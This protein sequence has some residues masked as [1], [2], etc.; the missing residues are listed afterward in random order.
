MAYQID[1][2][3]N[4]TLT[5]VEDG[6]VDQT[7]DLKF[8]GKNYAGYGE[9]QNEN[10]LFLLENFSGATAPARPLSGQIW[11]DTSVA[12]LKF[13][14]G[15]KWRTNGGSEAAATQPSG[16]SIGDFW[17]DTTN[18]QL[19]VYNG[20]I[21][22]LV[23]PQN[24]GDGV[25]Q[26]QSLEL[27]D[28][29]GT[30]RNVIAGTLNS[31]TVM[32]LSVFE[33]DI[34]ASNAITGFDRLKK[35]I[36]LINTKLITDGVTTPTGHYFWGT[37]SDSLRLGGDLAT[38]FIKEAASGN[39][40]LTTVF[41]FPDSGIQIGNSQDL[42]LLVES[43]SEGVIQ[44]VTGNNSKIKIKTTD[45]AGTTT[46]SVTFDASGIVPSIDN[47][48]A[49][50]SSTN[51]FSN[52][53]ATAF[54]GEAS[55]ATAL[56][57]GSDFRTASASAS[58][59]TVAVRDATGNIAANLFQGTATTARYADLAEIYSTDVDYPVGTAIAVGGEVEARS[60]AVGDV[61]IG[62]IS[63]NPAYLMNAEADG[64]AVGLKGRVPVRVS[65]PVS[66][67]QAVY[68]WNDG[69]CST[70][71]TNAIVGIALETNSD[72]GEKLVECVLKV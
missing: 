17:W 60:A 45:G 50:G 46:H 39:T 67:G 37:A 28:T 16:L 44:N 24:A 38:Q 49:L 36:T 12:K 54:T 47:T 61:C 26:M 11:Y 33:F 64:Q 3:N 22:I 29:G 41:E 57:V 52:V 13:Y 8:I 65:G 59:N 14:D 1:R 5:N 7:T 58:N 62:V 68:A 25:T 32:I 27:L 51:K 10:F 48:F 2:Y 20:T 31:E 56:R 43:G 15:T 34:A 53:H 18:D 66:K 69:V 4:T 35:G 6:T 21:F 55:Q 42:Q 70:I 9:I 71:T 40:I 63:D 72:E 30:T 19:Y 23:G